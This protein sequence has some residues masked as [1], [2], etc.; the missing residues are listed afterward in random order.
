MVEMLLDCPFCGGKAKEFTG[1]DAAPFRWTV[2]C[3]VCGARVGSDTRHKAHAK[4]NRRTER[5][6]LVVRSGKPSSTGVPSERRCSECGGRLSRFG[7][8]CQT[9]GARVV[10]E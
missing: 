2:E 5:T 7:G 9:C 4:W 3:D 6:C 8:F 1:E 10:S